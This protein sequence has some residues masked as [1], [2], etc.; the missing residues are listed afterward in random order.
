MKIVLAGYIPVNPSQLADVLAEYNVNH[1]EIRVISS[2]ETVTGKHV[3]Y[4]LVFD[5]G[6]VKLQDLRQINHWT[7]SWSAGGT[8]PDDR[9]MQRIVTDVNA[10]VTVPAIAL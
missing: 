7:D 10:S 1:Q 2:K 9:P 8:L 3:L 6:S 5:R 4:L